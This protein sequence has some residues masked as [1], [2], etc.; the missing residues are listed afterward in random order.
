[1][2]T[3]FC[4]WNCLKGEIRLKT[5]VNRPVSQVKMQDESVAN[6][7]VACVRAQGGAPKGSGVSG[8]AVRVFGR[9]LLV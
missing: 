7:R 9:S 4:F 6:S 3:S 5:Q 1:M 2:F 8:E